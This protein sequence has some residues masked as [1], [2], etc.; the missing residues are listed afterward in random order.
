MKKYELTDETK[1]WGMIVLHRIKALKNF[2]DVKAGDLGGWVQGEHNLSQEGES[3]I[4]D[5][6]VAYQNSVVMD[7]AKLK[8]KSLVCG[9]VKIRDKA[10]IKDFAKI[11]DVAEVY[12]SAKVANRAV[13]VDSAKVFGNA[14]VIDEALIYEEAVICENAIVGG[15][16]NVYG[17]AQI[18]G[19]TYIIDTIGIFSEAVIKSNKDW[20]MVGLVGT[21]N[22]EVATF[23][24]TKD[25]DIVV[26]WGED[27]YG[28]IENLK[29]N[30][31]DVT[32]D[33][34]EIKKI[35]LSIELAEIHING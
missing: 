34:R 31:N 17:K 12:G 13:I 25:N 26:N 32:D 9:A 30:I 22:E 10:I 8:D 5:E 4:Y 24:K 15:Y 3:W 1:N 18:S 35:N 23:F 6:A 28:T 7:N 33:E 20:F 14:Q 11:L 2:A 19:Y 21:D 29:T 27:F 16:A